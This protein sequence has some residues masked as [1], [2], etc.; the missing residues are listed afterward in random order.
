MS[1]QLPLLLNI[2]YLYHHVSPYTSIF[3]SLVGLYAQNYEQL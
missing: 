1:N 2:F 3:Q